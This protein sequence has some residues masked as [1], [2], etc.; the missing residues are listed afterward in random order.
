MQV[1]SSRRFTFSI[2]L[3]A[4]RAVVPAAVAFAVTAV[5]CA[6]VAIRAAV[7][8][9]A[10]RI[11]ASERLAAGRDVSRRVAAVPR[12]RTGV[13]HVVRATAHGVRA[14]ATRGVVT[15]IGH[16]A[17]ATRRNGDVV[18]LSG[19]ARTRGSRRADIAGAA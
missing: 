11:L 3:G 14:A 17:I 19:C 13:P 4:L 5:A 12:V 10:L 16:M 7:A 18:T 1:P 9:I 6:G 2:A 15:P 8:A